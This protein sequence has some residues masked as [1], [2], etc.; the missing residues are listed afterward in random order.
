[1]SDY[2][3]G[4]VDTYEITWMSGHIERVLAHQVS[5]PAA[6]M[7]LMRSMGA[8]TVGV[9][10]GAPRVRMRAEINGRWTLTLSAREE[11]IRTMRL[12]TEPERI[13]GTEADQ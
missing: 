11:D 2:D 6:G 10:G 3:Y 1:M 12:V 13:P 8:V 4:P 5:Y 7:A 9:E